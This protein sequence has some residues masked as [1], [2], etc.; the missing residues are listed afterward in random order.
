MLGRVRKKLVALEVKEKDSKEKTWRNNFRIEKT[1]RNLVDTF[2]RR[3]RNDWRKR[4]CIE[5]VKRRRRK[6][7]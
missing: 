2:G 3:V 5:E 1:R 7:I 4:K 6:V